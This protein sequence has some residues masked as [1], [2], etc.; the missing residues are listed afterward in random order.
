MTERSALK[1]AR[2]E[3][4]MEGIIATALTML[5]DG[6]MYVI[7]RTVKAV[8]RKI[9]NQLERINHLL[10]NIPIIQINR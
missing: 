4:I 5:K 10:Q 8:N 7:Y 6:M 1:D 9:E 3:G 2:K